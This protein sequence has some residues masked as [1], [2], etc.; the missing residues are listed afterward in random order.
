MNVEFPNCY[1]RSIFF[2]FFSILLFLPLQV[3]ALFEDHEDSFTAFVEPFVILLILIANAIVGVWQVSMC[4]RY[5]YKCVSIYQNAV[6]VWLL[7]IESASE[8]VLVRMCGSPRKSPARFCRSEY[9]TH[10]SIFQKQLISH[11]CLLLSEKMTSNTERAEQL[12]NRMDLKINSLKRNVKYLLR[13]FVRKQIWFFAFLASRIG[14]PQQ[15]RSPLPHHAEAMNKI[16]C[17]RSSILLAAFVVMQIGSMKYV[18]GP[19]SP[20]LIIFANFINTLILLV[21]RV[22]ATR[23]LIKC[24]LISFS[25]AEAESRHV[26]SRYH[27]EFVIVGQWPRKPVASTKCCTAIWCARG[28]T[29][30]YFSHE[31]WQFPKHHRFNYN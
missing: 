18:N 31:Y 7:V 28:C 10:F 19:I 13:H 14:R 3:L 26:G 23:K 25:C 4:W 5:F 24:E 27:L 20:S 21:V 15:N 29:F 8:Y 9:F 12:H 16:A 17:C 1:R 11:F 22:R 6:C 30:A 2:F